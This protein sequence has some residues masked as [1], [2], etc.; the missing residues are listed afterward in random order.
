MGAREG[1]TVT[2]APLY[3]GYSPACD[4]RKK[5][6]LFPAELCPVMGVGEPFCPRDEPCVQSRAVNYLQ[7]ELRTNLL[8]ISVNTTV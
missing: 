1:G 7:I 4:C 2:G 8:Q 3:A 5:S 6:E